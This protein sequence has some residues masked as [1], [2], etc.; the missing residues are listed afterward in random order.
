MKN[1]SRE[2]EQLK[3]QGRKSEGEAEGE[4]ERE[5]ENPLKLARK[6]NESDY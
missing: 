2:R 3:K 4:S 1:G 5:G 6:I